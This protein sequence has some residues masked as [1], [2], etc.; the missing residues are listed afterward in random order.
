M[1]AIP[2]AGF[3]SD[4]A[5]P[6]NWS[7]DNAESSEVRLEF[8]AKSFAGKRSARVVKTNGAGYSMMVSDFVPVTAGQTYQ[9]SAQLHV[10]GNSRAR[11]TATRF[12]PIKNFSRFTRCGIRRKR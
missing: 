3:E 4:A 2:N 8:G 1:I 5:L 10:E 7:F 9:L 11:I 6:D 12:T